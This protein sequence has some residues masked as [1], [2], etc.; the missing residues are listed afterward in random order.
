MGVDN[1][2][3]DQFTSKANKQTVVVTGVSIVDPLGG[4]TNAFFERLLS[5]FC[6]QGHFRSQY[7]DP[8][9]EA[10][11]VLCDP[12]DFSARWGKPPHPAT[13]RYAQLGI[14]AGLEAWQ[15][16]GLAASEHDPDAGVMWGTALGG[17]MAYESGLDRAWIQNK[18]RSSPLAVVQG[19]N[20]SCASHLAI[21]LGLGNTCL[22]YSVACSSAGAAIGE[23]YRRIADGHAK[24]ML[25]GGSDMPLLYGV[26]KA[27]QGMRVL[28]QPVD[29]EGSPACLP[30]DARR[31][32]LML[33]EGAA[34]L[35]LETLESAQE[36][37]APILAVLAGYG[38]N[39]DH[40]NLV[41]PNQPGQVRAMQAALADA[42]LTPTDIGYVNAH[43]TATHEGDPI[44][45]A[46][47]RE[48]F[49]EHAAN[50]PV[51]ATKASHGHMMGATGA[52]EAVISVLALNRGSIPPTANLQQIDP[53]CEGVRHVKGEAL[54]QELNAV[55]SN[56]FAFGGSNAVLVFKQAD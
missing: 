20:N 28:A 26:V 41:R 13:D 33:G 21:D 31:N 53:A 34:A 56:S 2:T 23:G 49:G 6:Y 30:F 48:V 38:T 36:R 47:I 46:G 18:P 39:C 14:Y 19:M 54:S 9:V 45:I 29:G 3:T 42:Q 44:E 40:N 51:S 37:G 10:A 11:A 4:D 50:L 52:V 8:A 32:G 55:M 24:R 43:G 35:V 1:Q 7:G 22:T 16:A 25:V 27:W 5:G 12:F 17:M 15:Q